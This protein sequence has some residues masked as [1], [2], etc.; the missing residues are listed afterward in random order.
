MVNDALRRG[1]VR[2]PAL[3]SCHERVDTGP[4]CRPTLAMRE[5]LLDLDPTKVGDSK[6]EARLVRA[7]ARAGLPAP[8]LGHRAGRYR[9]DLA[10]PDAKIAVEFDSWEFHRTQ[11][12]FHN[13]RRRW[14]RLTALGWTVIPVTSRTDLDE[15][16]ADLLSLLGLCAPSAAA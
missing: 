13:D 9:I 4:G 6:R 5:V 8:V 2:L 12:A 11:T 14:R 1:L 16:V 7:L 3:R 15:L 10:W